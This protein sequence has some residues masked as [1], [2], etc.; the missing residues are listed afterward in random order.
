MTEARSD[1]SPRK[2]GLWMTLSLV[3]GNMVGAGI[4]LLPAS[5][6]IF[7]GISLV[8]W[9]ASTVGALLLALVFARLSAV[10]PAPGG[11]YAYSRRGFGD[12]AGFLVAWGYWIAIMAGNAAIAV[13][14]VGYLGTFVPGLANSPVLAVLTAL[15]AIWL[16][17]WV[18]A[19]GVR[20]AGSVQ[21]VSTV[22]KFLP[23]FAI[24]TIGLLYL[25]VD[26]FTPF[27]L[28]GE[29]TFGAITACTALTFW[30]FQG[31]ESASIPA[32]HIENPKRTIPK[33]TVLGTLL[34]GVVYI[35]CTVGVMGI[36]SPVILADSTA[37]FA[38][39]AASIWGGW[40]G[41]AVAA[42]AVVSTLGALNGWILLQAQIPYAAAKDGVFPRLFSHVSPKGVPITGL[43]ISSVL[44]TIL[45]ATNYTQGLVSLFTFMVL[46]A[47]LSALI[48]YAFTAM[49]EIMIYVREP[50]LFRGDRFGRAVLLAGL[51]FA[52]SIWAIGGTG[53]ATVF[54]GFLLLMVGIP[55][56]VWIAW[57]ERQTASSDG[58]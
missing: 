38:D 58:E 49:A 6:A 22:L 53:Q 2:M 7:G 10:A 30:A 24:G 44:I 29:T 46:L 15:T 25:Q 32:G 48:P 4:F 28:S 57:R 19:Q 45:M 36:L 39:A 33:A 50:E 9:A 26:H 52:Y 56:Y 35:L 47:T 40:A 20:A 37:P 12:F 23:L 13:A 55:V 14:F 17:T 18:N 51:A 3:M 27:N 8:G 43:V 42:G 34:T 21:L 54:W 16:L 31:F 41:R 11:P 1:D 5:L